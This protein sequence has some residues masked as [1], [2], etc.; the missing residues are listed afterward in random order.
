MS[1]GYW[2]N[3]WI[4]DAGFG[5]VIGPGEDR[6]SRAW[7]TVLPGVEQGLPKI[8]KGSL[9]FAANDGKGERWRWRTGEVKNKFHVG[10]RVTISDD[11]AS[12]TVRDTLTE[13]S[14]G[15]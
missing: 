9:F 2:G 8:M 15:G 10:W 12:Y 7:G 5:S 11:V 1:G 14:E 3:H 13:D 6:H 4:L